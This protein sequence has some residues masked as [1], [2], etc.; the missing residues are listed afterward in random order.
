MYEG[1]GCNPWDA[2]GLDRMVVHQN[3]K[4]EWVQDGQV[5]GVSALDKH[6]APMVPFERHRVRLLKPLRGDRRYETGEQLEVHMI[7]GG[8]VYIL[9]GITV[10]NAHAVAG[11]DF[12]FL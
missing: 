7:P 8:A 2:W 1:K 11:V 3:E 6:G 9:D 12:E 10:I 4:G 5:I